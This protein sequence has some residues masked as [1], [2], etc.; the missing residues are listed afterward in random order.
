MKFPYGDGTWNVNLPNGLSYH[1]LSLP[2]PP[3]LPLGKVRERL[4][5]MCQELAPRVTAATHCTVLIDD[6]S[7]PT[8]TA[9]ILSALLPH[10]AAC[11]QQ[12]IQLLIANGLHDPWPLGHYSQFIP[13]TFHD[14]VRLVQH[15]A[16]S[17]CRHFGHTQRG[18]PVAIN[19]LVA[20][21][22][23]V[24]SI[25]H[26][27]PHFYAGYSGGRKS[28]VPGCA[29]RS[30][31]QQNHRLLVE[32]K[33]R[34]GILRHNPLHLDLVEAA[35]MAGGIDYTIN[36]VLSPHTRQIVGIF[37]G[38]MLTAHYQACRL[39]AAVYAY[40]L[41]H[42]FD[43]ILVTPGGHSSDP[44]LYQAHD[45]NLYHAIDVLFNLEHGLDQVRWVVLLARCTEGL[46][47]SDFWQLARGLR[48][49]D[50]VIQQMQHQGFRRGSYKA[51]MLARLLQRVRIMLVSAL[52]AALVKQMGIEP[53]DSPQEAL[54]QVRAIGAQRV[55][56]VTNG[57]FALASH[58]DLQ[59]MI[60]NPG[61]PQ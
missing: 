48:A 23:F 30:T 43:A 27:A 21:A 3:S 60:P 28:L 42:A 35:T 58:T 8:P 13:E 47:R 25:G 46:G 22:D 37:G 11:T 40:S 17:P 53:L 49:P 4:A 15:Q 2:Q 55:L 38:D 56:L 29:A 12:T 39:A 52:D 9:L 16:D 61:G 1:T 6:L 20:A 31:I 36:V 45:Q 5:T 10:L 51:V 7:R 57:R 19:P 44:R 14:Q 54:E 34:A 41:P 18:T 32:T 50:Q 33:A 59:S 24:I 26:V